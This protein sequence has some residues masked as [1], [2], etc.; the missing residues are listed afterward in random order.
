MLVAMREQRPSGAT[1]FVICGCLGPRSD[2]YQ[3]TEIMT[4]R[5]AENY[6]SVQLKSFT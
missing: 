6:R 3:P 1:A 2:A 5:E 4:P